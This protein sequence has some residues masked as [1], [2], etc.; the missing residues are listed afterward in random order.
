MAMNTTAVGGYEHYQTSTGAVANC[1]Y[2]E[3]R[4]RGQ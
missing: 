2:A 4:G 3:G 1:C